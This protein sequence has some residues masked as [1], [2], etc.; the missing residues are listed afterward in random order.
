M[1]L[2]NIYTAGLHN[3][4]SYQVAGRPW[5]SGSALSD[6]TTHSIRFQFP[7]VSKSIKVKTDDNHTI[8]IHFAP[9][10]ASYGYTNDASS[11]FNYILLDGPGEITLP[12]KAKE[13]FISCPQGAHGGD[14]VT[15]FAE[16]TEIPSGRMFSLDGV[17]GVSS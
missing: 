6:V 7:S 14:S 15:I 1:S 4:G 12:C 2:S 17:S 5:I 10:T 8:R 3:V 9:Y 11:S 13:I 16:L